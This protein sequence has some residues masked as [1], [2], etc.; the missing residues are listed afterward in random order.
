MFIKHFF[1]W[2]LNINLDNIL[3]LGISYIP[4]LFLT[5]SFFIPFKK[6]E[7]TIKKFYNDRKHLCEYKLL[8][9]MIFYKH[10]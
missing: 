3:Y 4:R 1:C 10:E 6:K 5:F 8:I 7:V 9:K 2:I